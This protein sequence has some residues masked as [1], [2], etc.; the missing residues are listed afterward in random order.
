MS[1]VEGLD[2]RAGSLPERLQPLAENCQFM[3]FRLRQWGTAGWHLEFGVVNGHL[4][5]AR[6]WHAVHP[7]KCGE[8]STEPRQQVTLPAS[9]V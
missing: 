6:Q 7:E 1:C 3:P 4:L 9:L 2:R 8:F 5:M